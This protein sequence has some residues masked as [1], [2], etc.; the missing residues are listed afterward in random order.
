MLLRS[1]VFPG[2][3]LVALPRQR[4]MCTSVAG[5]RLGQH[6]T[7]NWLLPD[8]YRWML[9]KNTAYRIPHTLKVGGMQHMVVNTDRAL[10]QSTLW[11]CVVMAG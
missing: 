6:S 9:S 8:Q 3:P 5:H 11:V 2:S 1:G 10:T 7:Y 4:G